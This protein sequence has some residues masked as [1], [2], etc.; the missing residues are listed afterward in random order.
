MRPRADLNLQADPLR[1]LI[2]QVKSRLN[3]LSSRTHVAACKQTSENSVQATSENI[4]LPDV[5]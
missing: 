4:P 3:A 2:L 1:A 5:R